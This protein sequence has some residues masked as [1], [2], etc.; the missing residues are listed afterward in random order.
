M[1]LSDVGTVQGIEALDSVVE[2]D[3]VRTP[4]NQ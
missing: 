2:D 1:T 4:R 3:V